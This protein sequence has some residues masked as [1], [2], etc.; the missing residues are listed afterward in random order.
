MKMQG[1]FWDGSHNH[2][3]QWQAAE[4]CLG[5]TGCPRCAV[6]P[7]EA[8]HPLSCFTTDFLCDLGQVMQK[9]ILSLTADARG[10]GCP[11]A[12]EY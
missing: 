9:R 8:L 12:L 10:A 1:A 7:A 2:S 4:L 6:V 11:V 3:A 5:V